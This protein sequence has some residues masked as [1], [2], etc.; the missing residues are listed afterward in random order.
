MYEGQD[1][2]QQYACSAKVTRKR[3][4]ELCK[5]ACMA[6]VLQGQI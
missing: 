3:V 5:K 6:Y 2:Q 1:Q 4:D